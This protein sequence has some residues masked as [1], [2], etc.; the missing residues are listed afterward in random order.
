MASYDIIDHK[1]NTYLLKFPT[2]RFNKTIINPYIN[3]KEISRLFS[4]SSIKS[5]DYS[6]VVLLNL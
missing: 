1:P 3:A 5:I 6:V 4:G 2:L